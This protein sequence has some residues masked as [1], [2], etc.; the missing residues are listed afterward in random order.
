MIVSSVVVFG[1]LPALASGDHVLTVDGQEYSPTKVVGNANDPTVHYETPDTNPG[2]A[3]TERHDW[4]GNGS[5]KLPCEFGIH[6]I[7]NANVL[8]ISNCLEGETTTTTRE[9]EETTTTTEDEKSTTTTTQESTTTTVSDVTTT[10]ARTPTTSAI[11]DTTTVDT[12]TP[13]TFNVDDPCGFVTTDVDIRFQT[14]LIDADLVPGSYDFSDQVSGGD[15]WVIY[16]AGTT[17]VLAEGVFK[18]SCDDAPI[19]PGVLPFTGLESWQL[20]AIAM[21][22]LAGGMGLVTI[23][24]LRTES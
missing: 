5:E 24:R 21:A 17:N 10:T 23:A 11:T 19:T 20:V 6:W 18:D 9:D 22:L 3:F 2:A 1:M 7:D 12:T 8:T 16:E 14:G 4:V 13:S 15:A